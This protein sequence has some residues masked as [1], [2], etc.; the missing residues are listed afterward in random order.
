MK[1]IKG[2]KKSKSILKVQYLSKS[3]LLLTVGETCRLF[4]HGFKD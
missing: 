2:R 4:V 3:T 1:C